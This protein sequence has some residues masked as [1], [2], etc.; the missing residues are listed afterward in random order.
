MAVATASSDA[1]T[2]GC[3]AAYRSGTFR[4]QISEN[5]RV[6]GE[7]EIPP[8]LVIIGVTWGVTVLMIDQLGPPLFVARLI[9]HR[10]RC[11]GTQ[12]LGGRIPVQPA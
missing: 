1:V 4:Q 8:Q 7:Q 6:T 3:A 11:R 9:C 5:E 2:I 12:W 10:G